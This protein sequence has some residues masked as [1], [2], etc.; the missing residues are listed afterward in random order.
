MS[1]HSI[2]PLWHTLF[3]LLG[4]CIIILCY[5]FV[6]SAIAQT[7]SVTQNENY[8][9]S[10]RFFSM[11]NGM[12]SRE[13]FCGVQ[14]KEGFLW[15]GSRNGLN[16]FD[17]SKFKLYTSQKN[18]LAENKIVQLAIDDANN[19]FILYGQ[20]GYQLAVNG[21]VQVMNATT[22]VVQR[23]QD[24][25]PNIPFKEEDIFW[26][27]NNGTNNLQFLTSH[28][29][30][31]WEYNTSSGFRLKLE[32][33]AWRKNSNP[34]L[35]FYQI[36]GP[37][38]FFQQKHAFLKFEINDRP[39][40]VQTDTAFALLPSAI[41]FQPLV[42]LDSTKFFAAYRPKGNNNTWQF[43]ELLVSENGKYQLESKAY[44]NL[45]FNNT[46]CT[47]SGCYNNPSA[48]IHHAAEGM[49]L[50]EQKQ[51]LKIL[52][53][54][55]IPGFQNMTVYRNFIDRLGNR[56]ICTS[57]GI[58]QIKIEK[59]RFQH[60]FSKAQQQIESNN[61]TRGI[62][63]DDNSNTVYANLWYHFFSQ[64][65]KKIHAVKYDELLYAFCKH[66]N[67]Y[68]IGSRSLCS[69][70]TIDNRMD[71]IPDLH[72][73]QEIWSFYPLTNSVLLEGRSYGISRYYVGTKHV[74]DVRYI[75]PNL[76]KAQFVYRFFQ[77]KGNLLWAVAENGL[78]Q[79]NAMG[80]ILD[81]YGNYTNDSTR[82]LPVRTIHDAYE[83]HEGI[84]WIAS[85]GNGLLR[86]DR[87]EKQTAKGFTLKT[88]DISSG[89]PSN[90][91]YRMEADEN[92]HLWVSTDFGLFR[93]HTSNYSINTYTTRHGISNNEYNRISSFKSKSGR[94]FF[95]GL[96][97]I[98]A[99]HP[100]DFA[101]D[102]AT[103]DIPLRVI[104]F[105]QF[106]GEENKLINA[107][108]QLQTDKKI[109]MHSGDKF[110]NMEFVLLDFKEGQHH[111]AYKIEGIDKDWNYI[112]E[113]SIRISGLPYGQF[114]LHVKGQ[115]AEGNWSKYEL[116]FPI[117]VVI[118]FYRKA[119]FIGC[120]LLCLICLV[121]ILVRLRIKQ[122]K[123]EKLKLES[124]VFERTEALQ[125][126]LE[127]KDELLK[128][129]HH[130]VKNNLQIISSLLELQ[131]LRLTDN[132]AK[133]AIEEGQSRVQSIAILH[134]QLYQHKDL[135]KV[136]FKTFVHELY[137]Q[138]TSVFKSPHQQVEATIG[139]PEIYMDI[140]TAV[141]LG[142]ILNEL[143][144]NSFK[145]AHPKSNISAQEIDHAS[146]LHIEITLQRNSEGHI[147]MRYKDN[148]VGLPADFN[149]EKAASLGLRIIWRL[150]KQIK[151]SCVYSF[152]EGATF[153]FQFKST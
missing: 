83:D 67:N 104:S 73:L 91:L 29:Y 43:G 48:I 88:F 10:T 98:D 115:D 69:Y 8:I 72:H 40:V 126:A 50:Q 39:Y 44:Q 92:H 18:G 70:N 2:R 5:C 38:S 90:I 94:I 20:T 13:V 23:I 117:E 96:D 6:Q 123:Q 137:L 11:E 25:I 78:Y 80:D 61:Q 107:L 82:K 136:E 28:P 3:R 112:Q 36:C 113:N 37:F 150:I 134:H 57:L 30:R 119:W 32:M 62:Y 52:E 108:D 121:F 109:I 76:P 140:D 64:Q 51:L 1:I 111:F 22:Q 41:E 122:L 15:F 145:Y 93:F 97:G 65:G 31:L 47:F 7:Q 148:G 74:E 106:K 14:D 141:P 56:W 146:R 12:A 60:Y 84:I 149:F 21:R 102:S 124:T 27:T 55:S 133:S 79:L 127:Q 116:N 152:D 95:G 63:Y 114:T 75:K 71:S 85:N 17:G 105:A 132:I 118:P 101:T 128:E 151:G 58:F 34:N 153:T 53:A 33:K 16:R 130:R 99:F 86:W 142:L 87:N 100:N 42:V 19:L 147:L 68:Y 129:I 135:S 9:V 138:I 143:F 77:G 89:L 81:Y 110:F 26:I 131:G 125:N 35:R 59:N 46:A 66:G 45:P 4:V 103:I 120:V 144:T 54:N 49:Y 139:I 24:A